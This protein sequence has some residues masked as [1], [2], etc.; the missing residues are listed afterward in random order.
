MKPY[1]IRRELL[2]SMQLLTGTA[3]SKLRSKMH[4]ERLVLANGGD[5][6]LNEN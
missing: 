4:A 3:L 1:V 6:H 2:L 5:V